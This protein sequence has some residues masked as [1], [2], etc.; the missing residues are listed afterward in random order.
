MNAETAILVTIVVS[1]LVL[2]L[3]AIF[4]EGGISSAVSSVVGSGDDGEGI[5]DCNPADPSEEC[6]EDYGG[7]EPS[8]YEF[9]V[10]EY[11]I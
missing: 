2:G 8:S 3:A 9:E 5:V 7:A 1:V 11:W 6:K 4:T 10:S